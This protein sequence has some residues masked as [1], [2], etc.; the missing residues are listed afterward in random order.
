MQYKDDT[1]KHG[2][3]QTKLQSII[4]FRKDNF[5]IIEEVYDSQTNT[6]VGLKV[7]DKIIKQTLFTGIK[8]YVYKTV[9]INEFIFKRLL[10]NIYKGV[11][12]VFLKQSKEKSFT[13][14]D[15][16]RLYYFS[17]ADIIITGGY[18]NRIDKE[19]G[20]EYKM[21]NFPIQIARRIL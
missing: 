14:K 16:Y 20:E 6:R 9:S 2:K 5:T 4:K 13:N 10:R 21:Y 11:L 19:S 1:Y 3:I 7:Y 17:K 12:I 8:E 15:K 18:N